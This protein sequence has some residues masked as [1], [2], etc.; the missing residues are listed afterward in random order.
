MNQRACAGKP[1]A[2]FHG[3]HLGRRLLLAL[4][5]L[6]LL[7]PSAA[8]QKRGGILDTAMRE[9]PTG[10]DQHGS[11]KSSARTQEAMSLTHNRLFMYPEDD[12]K[13]GGIVGDLVERWSQPDPKTYILHLYK[14]V[15]FHPK[16]PVNGRELTAEDVRWTFSRVMKSPEKRL[17]PTLK[18]VVAVDAHTLRFELSAPFG[19]F[20]PNLAATTMVIYAKDAGKRCESCNGGR[21]LTGADT[22]IGTGPFMLEDYREG[23]VLV[24]K[25]HPDYFR[26]GKPYIDGV[27]IYVMRDKATY[28]SAL[29]TG[30]VQLLEAWNRVDHVN[31]EE[32]AEF[33]ETVIELFPM[34]RTSENIIGR[35][36]KKP[37]NDLRVRRAVSLAVDR[38]RWVKGLFPKGGVRHSG[39]IPNV[40]EFY[41]AEKELGESARWYRYDPAEARRLLAEAGYPNGFKAKLYMTTGYGPDY[42]TRSAL[43]K[44]ML[45]KVGIDLAIVAQDYP[46]WIKG[47]YAGNF[48][49]WA[50]LHIPTWGLGDEDE[51]LGSYL[52]GDTRNQIHLQDAKFAEIVARSRNAPTLEGRA[53]AIREFQRAFHD[54]MLRVFLPIE[55]FVMLR[56]RNLM[57]YAPKMKG[58]DFGKRF[59]NVWFE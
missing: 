57:G 39:P 53:E 52:P 49:E 18:N 38:D 15:R 5:V 36:D 13:G 8:A 54:Q 50:L 16:P 56:K 37:W 48:P 10:F 1:A 47:T 32:A 6:A 3:V 43:I 45:G 26:K 51:W 31:A 17:F 44:D 27:N 2:G 35:L 42:T 24:Y 40:S 14:G 25:R 19:P 23:Q 30:K 12:R 7:A 33:P 58:Y 22:V 29:R 4:A 34:F 9:D 28:M 55:D 11:K 46:Q 59:E 21:D 20:I 41:L